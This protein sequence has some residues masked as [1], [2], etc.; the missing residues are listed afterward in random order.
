MNL[1]PIFLFTIGGIIAVQITE[2][3]FIFNAKTPLPS[4]TFLA[5]KTTPNSDSNP[6]H[7]QPQETGR[8]RRQDVKYRF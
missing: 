6:S 1:K 7:N 8:S 4:G 5:Q 3:N 2:I